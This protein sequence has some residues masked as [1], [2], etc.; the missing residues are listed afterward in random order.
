MENRVTKK[1]K[2]KLQETYEDSFDKFKTFEFLT[3][4]FP[5]NVTNKTALSGMP[6]KTD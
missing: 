6:T 1:K 4:N 5:Q 2:K 3:C